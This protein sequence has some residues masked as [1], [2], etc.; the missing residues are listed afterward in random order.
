MRQL[1]MRFKELESKQFFAL[2]GVAVIVVL[3][4]DILLI[5]RSQIGVITALSAKTAQLKSDIDTLLVN[6]QRM[7]Q[8]RLRL[9]GVRREAG[10][11]KAMVHREDEIPAVLKIVST[12]ANQYGVKIDQLVPQKNDGVVIV[13]NEDGKYTGLSILVK[14]RSGYHDLGR[15]LNRLEQEKVFWQ[16]E[17]LDITADEHDPARH[18]VKMQLKILILGER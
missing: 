2:L 12:F 4:V 7:G 6:E 17:S 13:A 9:D 16:I 5:V 10:G 18:A 11:F 3:A 14:A 1:L 15:F 8:L